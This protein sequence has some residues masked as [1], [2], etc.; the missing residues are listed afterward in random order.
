M[1]KDKPVTYKQ[2]GVNLDAGDQ[3][4]ERIRHLL[5][6]THSP[7]VMGAHGGFA[8]MFRLDYNEKIFRRNY[9]EP[10]LVSCADGVGSKLKVAFQAGDVGTVGIDLVAM[11]V[12]DLIVCGAE[13]LFFLDYLGVGRL[14]PGRMA[15]I[16]AG[17]AEG[18]VRGDC[19]LLGGET[20]E[21]PDFYRPNEFDAAG[22]AVGVV[23]LKRI[24]DGRLIEPGD[25][26]IGLAS[27]GIHSNGYA[28][29]RRLV[30]EGAKLKVTDRVEELGETVGQALLRPT[31]IYVR[32]VLAV[33]RRYKR[34]RPVRGM[35]HVTGGGIEGNVPRC[36]PD[37][38][39]V[40]IR[41]GSWP[42]PPVFDWLAKLGP[43]DEDEMYRVFNMGVGFAMI[44][45]PAFVDSIVRQLTR[46]GERP[47]VI[48][49]V[50]RSRA[51]GVKF[52]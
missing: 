9:R 10:V 20:A 29:V 37:G 11:N 43:V 19:A 45:R 15:Q 2:A 38:L 51:G 17:V 23:D 22:F 31:R 35:A 44:V 4:V 24:I 8:G 6:R 14:E 12:N 42:V 33:L 18:C 25:V 34:K 26:V 41:K 21:L 1:A 30:F 36:L 48:G 47:H 7:R 27:D 52:R 28:L 3:M 5:R 50:V 16:V 39:G 13:P 32:P 40:E 49:K 46:A